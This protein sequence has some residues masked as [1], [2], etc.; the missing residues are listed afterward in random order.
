[1][2]LILLGYICVCVVT[3]VGRVRLYVCEDLRRERLIRLATLVVW[4]FGSLVD[5]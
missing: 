5:W 4:K 1:M 2:Y 3:Y